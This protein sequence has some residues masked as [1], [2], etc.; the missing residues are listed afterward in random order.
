MEKEIEKFYYT[1]DNKNQCKS[2]EIKILMR[3]LNAKEEKEWD[4][5][6][7]GKFR[8]RTR[9]ERGRKSR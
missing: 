2:H 9:N 3:D 6:I 1:L 7:F 4:D 5:E 8:L